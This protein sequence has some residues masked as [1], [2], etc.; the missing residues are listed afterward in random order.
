MKSKHKI[1]LLWDS[2]GNC[3]DGY[4]RRSKYEINERERLECKN[5]STELYENEE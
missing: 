3:K 4:K 1:K 2:K 5:K